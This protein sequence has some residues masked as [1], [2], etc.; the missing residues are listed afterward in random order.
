MARKVLYQTVKD[1]G[2]PQ[3]IITDGPIHCIT[4]DAWLGHGYYFWDTFEKLGHWWGEEKLKQ[5]YMVWKAICDFDS[6]KCFDL[7]GEPEHI[8]L[9][10]S[11]VEVMIKEGID[12]IDN[13]TVPE[14]LYYMRDVVGVLSH[15]HATRAMG[16]LSI[17]GRNIKYTCRMPFE[18]EGKPFLD[19]LP[20]IQIC[21]YNLTAMKFTNHHVIYPEKY[22]NAV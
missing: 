14:A 10:S 6:D 4:D 8:A 21:I 12:E 18:L 17:A 7:Y 13:I 5:D 1:K 22:K 2:N 20:P 15:Y 11:L 19:L 16:A 3:E 9:F